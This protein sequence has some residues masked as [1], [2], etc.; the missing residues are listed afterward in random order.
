MLSIKRI[1][2][3]FRKK[4]YQQILLHYQKLKLLENKIIG[5]YTAMTVSFIN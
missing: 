5:K 3:S 2:D 4:K 1:P